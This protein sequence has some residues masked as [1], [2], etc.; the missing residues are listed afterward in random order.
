M[1]QVKTSYSEL[2][3]LADCEKKWSYRYMGERVD[4]PPSEAMAKGTLI[5]GGVN[6]FWSA[7]DWGRGL[8]QAWEELGSRYDPAMYEQALADA[9]W[10]LMRYE[11]VYRDLIGNAEVVYT[12]KR[13]QSKIPGTSFSLFGYVD[14]MVRIAGKLW[15]VE[16]KTMKDWSRLDLITVDPQQ[17]IYFDLASLTGYEPYGILF[18]AIRTYRWKPE[19]PTQKQLIEEAIANGTRDLNGF[20]IAGL[21]AAGQRDWA[22][23]AVELHPGVERPA[24]ES[25]QQLWIDRTP[26]QIESARGWATTIMKRRAQLK[27]GADPIRNI[28]PFC[29]TCPFQAQCF[30]ELSFPQSTIEMVDE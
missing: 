18:D 19:K 23:A 29:K 11:E 22:R 17:T 27:R 14:R 12:E 9:E 2:S 1:G 5:H 6:G 16:T 13:L 30:D 8:E 7:G 21:T 20:P 15:L 3:V 28:G 4:T 25:F 10:I 26:E 24:H